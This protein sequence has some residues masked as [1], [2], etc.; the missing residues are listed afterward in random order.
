MTSLA[1]KTVA[2]APAQA[3]D[4]GDA[5]KLTDDFTGT[6]GPGRLVGSKSSNGDQRKGVDREKVISADNG[7]A[8]IAPLIEP[9]WGRAG[10]AYGPFER[11][12]GRA[13]AVYLV[14]CHNT[15]QSENLKESFRER[16]DRW[17]RGPD[18]C[19]RWQRF[20]QFLASKRKGRMLRQVL[21]WWR[22]RVDAKPVPKVDENL[23]IGFFPTEAPS[24]PLN[25]G[26]GFVMHATG[27]EN[28]E[29]WARCG[30]QC[31]PAV[32]SVQNLQIH[33]VVVLRE[34]GAIYYASS[35]PGANGL[36]TYPNMRPLAID[37]F[38]D[39]RSVYAGV[40]Q[41]ALG[42]IGFRLDTRIYGVRV[43]DLAQWTT[44]WGSAHAADSLKGIGTLSSAAAEVGG[45]WQQVAGQFERTSDGAVATRD[46]SIAV[47]RTSAPSGLI[48]VLAHAGV[49]T[50]DSVSVIWRY[51]DANNFW[52]LTLSSAGCELALH[53]NG[54]PSRIAYSEAARL[55][56]GSVHSLQVLDEGNRLGAFVD[57]AL[58]F[59]ERFRDRRLSHATGVGIAAWRS[60]DGARLAS[61]EAHPRE[62]PLPPSLDQGAPW[63]RMGKQAIVTDNFE[64]PP[65]ELDGKP[66]TSGGKT[67]GKTIGSGF[68]DVTGDES[69]KF[70]ATPAQRL[71]GRLAYTVEW[72]HTEFADL[73][74]VLTP[75]GMAAGQHQH[76]TAGF[77]LWQDPDN[78]LMLNIWCSDAYAGASISSFFYLDG[79]E[80][81]YD[82]IWTNVGR[83]MS[84]GESHVLRLT[85]DGM[86]Y[87]AFI[88]EEPVLYRALTDVYPDAR[89]LKI[90]RVGLLGN[91]EWGTDTGSVLRQFKARV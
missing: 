37:A 64:G 25:T 28:G 4:S 15:S 86:R 67:W 38:N 43:V 84:W 68:V 75:P 36:G 44:G 69:A 46:E 32:R 59:G 83:R 79:F 54:I 71:P 34:R 2:A 74:V 3:A 17:L 70:R 72:D 12:N 78:Y 42:Q 10:I 27:A 14:N 47:V 7:A 24:N 39:D 55:R 76:G 87:M 77:V 90:R 80:D 82:A 56:S 22:I 40:H 19:T 5:I 45:A 91:W 11:R 29:L 20:F 6:Y 18:L 13:L 8:R 49:S 16:V 1:K 21:W 48:H 66:T 65:R 60:V 35:V 81:L 23:A 61:F 57:G 88:D 62:C 51:A 58:V 33:Y 30:D 52:R 53:E 9:G 31:L 26:N 50:E 85:F 89:Q 41:A 63:W 73:E